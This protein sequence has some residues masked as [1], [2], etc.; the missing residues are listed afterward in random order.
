M[1]TS[2]GDTKTNSDDR[3]KMEDF[4]CYDV[5]IGSGSDGE[6]ACDFVLMIGIAVMLVLMCSRLRI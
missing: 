4:D 2:L 6:D 5:H 3:D 1:P